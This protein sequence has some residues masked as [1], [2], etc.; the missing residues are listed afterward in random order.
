MAYDAREIANFLLDHADSVNQDVTVMSLLK[1]IYFCHGWHLAS[2]GQP[3]IKNRIEAWK[4]G[5]VI[6][7]LYEQFKMFRDKKIS[8]RA[9]AHN[10][11]LGYDCPVT[12]KISN[13]DKDFI[14][15]V[16][17]SYASLHAFRLS[18]ITHEKN[19]PWDKVWNSSVRVGMTITNNEI[20]EHFLKTTKCFAQ[21]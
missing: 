9:T 18:D 19:S 10:F 11:N 3:L 14:I 6:P 1:I 7:I 21:N 17:K 12:Y 4:Y 16:Y 2:T 5:P 15:S 8:K 20:R 13:T